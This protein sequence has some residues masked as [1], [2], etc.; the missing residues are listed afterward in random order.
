MK[1]ILIF[2]L[3]WTLWVSAGSLPTPETIFSDPPFY[4]NIPSAI[5]WSPAD[6]AVAF[7][8]NKNGYRYGDIWLA[9]VPSGKLRQLTS[10]NLTNSTDPDKM[11]GNLT[12]FPKEQKLLF[13]Y[14]GDIY[15]L[16]A[17]LQQEPI[18]LM[19]TDEIEV[20]P[21]VSPDEKYV[22]FARDDFF[23]LFDLEQR[24]E[25]P[26]I[27]ICGNWQ[28]ETITLNGQQR[29]ALPYYWSPSGRQIAIPDFIGDFCNEILLF[30]PAE[31]QNYLRYPIAEDEDVLVCDLLWSPDEEQ[32]VI[33]YLS[34][35]LRIRNIVRVSLESHQI[36]TLYSRYSEWWCPDFG[37]KLCRADQGTKVLFGDVQSGYQ[38]LFVTG[39]T[40]ATPIALTRGKWHV[41]DY[42]VREQDG[43][44]FFSANQKKLTEKQIYTIDAKTGKVSNVSYKRGSHD[45]ILSRS[46]EYIIDHFSTATIPSELYL[47]QTL[48]V[49]KAQLLLK[50]DARIP[51]AQ[52]LDQ[53]LTRKLLD[54][55][56]GRELS[57]TLWYPEN[58]RKSD[59][60][61]LLVYLNEGK[62]PVSVL[63]EWKLSNLIN[64]W[65]S[66][67]GYIVAEINY[68]TLPLTPDYLSPADSLEPLEIQLGAIES[69]LEVLT[70]E[71]FIDASRIGIWGF[72]YGGYLSLMTTLKS[73]AR[74]N[75]AAAIL[76]ET[77]WTNYYSL[78][79]NL[80]LKEIGARD[81]RI[82]PGNPDVTD[83]WHGKLL[84]SQGNV[85]PLLP[86]IDIYDF[87][88]RMTE[89]LKG[90][91]FIF[92]PW[93]GPALEINQTY[94]DI[95]IK[96]RAFLSQNF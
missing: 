55:V 13:T 3:S 47:I 7:V 80:L 48:P 9:R 88:Q 65:I 95:L 50:P 53:S 51:G 79:D 5:C 41:F 25:V 49:S 90:I 69:V 8:W 86:L 70:Q 96:F 27:H 43:Q 28:S 54:P 17:G 34:K 82:T 63:D 39:P 71:S 10:F 32:W 31:P 14:S 61:P 91:D 40:A 94:I 66:S 21:S 37:G 57:Y 59:K 92:Y 45:F 74:I 33:D 77:N 19:V 1:R 83:S 42:A 6:S 68:P 4:G 60:F 35:D 16:S 38:H 12:W 58:H 93:D 52:S 73:P 64:Q 30:N 2:L 29:P 72:G 84:V 15:L 76:S 24:S 22:A 62:G 20:L 89:D 23:Y 36:D 85:S 78:Y 67:S 11:I 75:L 87:C 26:L 46:G 56:T 18:A 44:V 81:F